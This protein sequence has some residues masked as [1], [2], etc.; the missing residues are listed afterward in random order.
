[1]TVYMSIYWIYQGCLAIVCMRL[2]S[3]CLS[4]SR[5]LTPSLHV[6][7][8]YKCCAALTCN[9]AGCT[10]SQVSEKKRQAVIDAL[11]KYVFMV[12]SDEVRII[13]TR[14]WLGMLQGTV[15]CCVQYAPIPLCT[16]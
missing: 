2:Q 3:E 13:L 8:S 5:H 7:C 16:I 11:A 6:P 14:Q 10:P 9:V 12:P 4:L 1:M 15:P